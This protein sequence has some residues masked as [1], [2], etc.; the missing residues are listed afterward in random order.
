MKKIIPFILALLLLA[1]CQTPVPATPAGTTEGSTTQTPV[2]VITTK[3]QV[4]DPQLITEDEAK[5]LALEHAGLNEGAIKSYSIEL[6]W[7]DYKYEIEFFTK[8]I[9]YEYEINAI[10]GEIIEADKDR[11]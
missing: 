2:S 7:D 5:K 8:G 10:T 3:P 11:D 9:E 1:G 4:T 6:D